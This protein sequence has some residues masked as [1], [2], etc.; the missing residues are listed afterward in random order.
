MEMSKFKAPLNN[1]WHL[2]WLKTQANIIK[3][4]TSIMIW[5]MYHIKGG[6]TCVVIL[7]KFIYINRETIVFENGNAF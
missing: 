4:R 3:E 2:H 6:S 7:T 5:E 1:Q